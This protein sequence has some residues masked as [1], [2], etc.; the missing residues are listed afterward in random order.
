MCNAM[1]CSELIIKESLWL[2][3]NNKFKEI[4][5]SLPNAD[6]SFQILVKSIQDDFN[7]LSFTLSYFI[8]KLVGN[9]SIGIFFISLITP[10][11]DF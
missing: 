10:F 6:T 1:I 3:H 2:F 11:T 8:M 5:N 9:Y 7:N 4:Q